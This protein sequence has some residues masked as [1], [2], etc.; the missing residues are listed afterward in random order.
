MSRLPAFAL[1]GVVVLTAG[2]G[3]G[4]DAATNS[5]M[6]PPGVGVVRFD[7]RIRVLNALVFP[8]VPPVRSFAV[9]S[10]GIANDGT[11]PDRLVGIDVVGPDGSPRPATVA[12]VGPRVI[13]AGGV[14]YLTAQQATSSA[15]ICGANLRPG[16]SVS[17]TFR[18]ER[19]DPV[20]N[21]TTVVAPPGGYWA[22]EEGLAVRAPGLQGREACVAAQAEA[23]QATLPVPPAPAV[24]VP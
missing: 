4:Q 24:A 21:V 16:T 11:E 19:A 17:L 9:L 23:Q 14:L 3:A 10:T 15:Y 6:A 7:D 2:C 5:V 13:P 18:F 1:G 20:R 22:Q 8:S 12:I